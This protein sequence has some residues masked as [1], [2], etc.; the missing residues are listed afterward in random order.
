MFLFVSTR[1]NA[2]QDSVLLFVSYAETYYTEY[3]VMYEAL[4]ASGY[5]VDVRSAGVG[6]AS[7]YTIGGDVVAQAN[8]LDGSSYAHF[9]TQFINMFS[10]PWNAALNAVPAT[11]PVNGSIQNVPSM[12]NYKALVIAGGT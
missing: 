12:Q 9:Q 4:T 7:T 8:G 3:I 1:T 11:I 10:I 2:Q 5:F 6:N